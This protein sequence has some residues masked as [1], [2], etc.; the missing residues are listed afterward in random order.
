M[1]TAAGPVSAEITQSLIAAALT[2]AE[3]LHAWLDDPAALGHYGIDP[4]AVDLASLADFAG[5]SE[6]IR[7]NPCRH[8]LPLTFRILRL[9]GIEIE[10]FRDYTALS[11]AR[12]RM[13]LLSLEDRLDGLALFVE[14]WAAADQTRSLVR[15]ILLH[16][17]TLAT[18]SAADGA[19]AVVHELSSDPLELAEALRQR[20]PDLAGVGR[21]V[22]SVVYERASDGRCRVLEID[23]SLA[24]LRHALDEDVTGCG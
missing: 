4:D 7:H 22:R 15:D 5:L 14:G 9:L 10:F 20:D 24:S 16:E 21:E 11:L 12:R 8:D 19:L 2:D 6:K 17:R 3:R 23:G 13:G 18:L 1:T